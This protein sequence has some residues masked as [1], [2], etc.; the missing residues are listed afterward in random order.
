ME[1]T[2]QRIRYTVE[3]ILNHDFDFPDV[4]LPLEA[5][6][7]VQFSDRNDRVKYV[8]RSRG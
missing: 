4:S 8:M 1:E 5:M 7:V 3:K 6:V 2:N